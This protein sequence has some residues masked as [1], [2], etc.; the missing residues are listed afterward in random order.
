MSTNGPVCVLTRKP[1]KQAM[2]Q[3][4]QENIQQN[5]PEIEQ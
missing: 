5:T 3:Q 1:K 4:E 2:Q